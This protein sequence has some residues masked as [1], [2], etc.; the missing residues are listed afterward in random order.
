VNP[1]YLQIDV[2]VIAFQVVGFGCL[3]GCGAGSGLV[4]GYCD[5]FV[6]HWVVDCGAVFEVAADCA[7]GHCDSGS[8]RFAE[9]GFP[10]P[11]PVVAVVAGGQGIG[12]GEEAVAVRAGQG[13]RR[14]CPHQV[15]VVPRVV[16]P[17]FEAVGAR[18]SQIHLGPLQRLGDS[19]P[20]L[21]RL[22]PVAF[23]E[24]AVYVGGRSRR[25][26]VVGVG[27]NQ[28]FFPDG[29][30]YRLDQFQPAV[31][32]TPPVEQDSVDDAGFDDSGG[33]L[34][35]VRSVFGIVE[36]ELEESALGP[37]FGQRSV[38]V[39]PPPLVILWQESP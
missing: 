8:R 38:L 17:C 14:R 10:E 35:Y 7:V 4:E 25:S 28:M 16:I 12:V 26:P 24:V 32:V 19:L 20:V 9:I 11:V 33:S 13:E 29:F 6:G 30:S 18:L 22:A 31:I 23:H 3:A 34:R 21:R 15:Q 37:A 27:D 39:S 2:T 1:G 36:I 5:G